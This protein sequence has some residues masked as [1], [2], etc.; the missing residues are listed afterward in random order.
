MTRLV[1]D[2]LVV[3][4]HYTLTDSAGEVIDTSRGGKPLSYLHG[5][6]NI[7]PGLENALTGK[8]IGDS[9]NVRVEPETGYG[10]RIPELVKVVPRSMFEGVDDIQPGMQFQAESPNGGAQL[11]TV[12]D[13]DGNSITID[14]NHPLAGKTL[15]FEV[16]IEDVREASSTEVS[17]GHVH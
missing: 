17:H 15:N 7:I 9:T 6:G 11:I 4:I 13:V 12:L 1:A 14:T 2:N 5:A 16:S 3:S 8:S 10:M